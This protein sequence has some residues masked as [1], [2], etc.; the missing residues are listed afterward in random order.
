MGRYADAVY[1]RFQTSAS[2]SAQ[3]LSSQVLSRNAAGDP[4]DVADA[5]GVISRAR[6]GALG[7]KQFVHSQDGSWSQTELRYYDNS[8]VSA[9][10]EPRATCPAGHALAWVETTE[11]ADGSTSKAFHDLLGR[12]VIALTRGFDG[13]WIGSMA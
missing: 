11:N 13:G 1:E 10:G 12:P 9:P 8:Q 2:G 4:L 7:R 3:L 6:Y 5:N